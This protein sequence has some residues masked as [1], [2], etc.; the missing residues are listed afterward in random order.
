MWLAQGAGHTRFDCLN[1]DRVEYD[2]SPKQAS[3]T[4]WYFDGV[5]WVA[6][7]SPLGMPTK[8]AW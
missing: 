7:S 6:L 2:L 4:R 1:R 8:G 5:M 3:G